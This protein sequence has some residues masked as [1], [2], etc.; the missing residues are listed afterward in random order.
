MTLASG[1]EI[2][3]GKN[4]TTTYGDLNNKVLELLKNKCQ[5]IG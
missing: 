3:N 5:N 4:N 2:A 1:S